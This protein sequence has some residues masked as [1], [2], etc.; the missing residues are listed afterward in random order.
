MAVP[1]LR[2]SQNENEHLAGATRVLQD[3]RPGDRLEA[4]ADT[5]ALTAVKGGGLGPV[6]AG[7]ARSLQRMAGN[8]AFTA[9][10]SVQREEGSEFASMDGSSVHD[11]VGKGGEPL[12]QNVATKVEAATGADV[13]AMRVVR[14]D[15]STTA[16][17]SAAY[18]SGNKI[19]VPSTFD[20]SSPKGEETGIHE[21]LHGL[22]QSRGAV[23]GTSVEGGVSV[24]SPDDAFEQEASKGAVDIQ[25][26]RPV[27][28]PLAGVS[29]ATSAQRMAQRQAVVAQ[30]NAAPDE[31]LAAQQVRL[32]RMDAEPE[33][34]KDEEGE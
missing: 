34:K 2:A 6:D 23:A 26:G 16:T 31:E 29:G 15:A 3:E 27:D 33:E 10:L 7:A 5:R 30:R 9:A 28:A 32:Q 1:H 4:D 12:P 8:G 13:S 21:T 19:V 22:Q 24:S 25:A 17:N 11:A 18:T 20:F 14:D